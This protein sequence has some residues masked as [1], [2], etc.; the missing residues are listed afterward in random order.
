MDN[1]TRDGIQ[2]LQG[3]VLYA[4][5]Y[6]DAATDP[7]PLGG[8]AMKWNDESGSSVGIWYDDVIGLCTWLCRSSGRWHQDPSWADRQTCGTSQGKKQ[9]THTDQH[10]QWVGGSEPLL[11]IAPEFKTKSYSAVRTMFGTVTLSYTTDSER[12]SDACMI[13]PMDLRP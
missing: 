11:E 9:R 2:G 1:W 8:D 3:A 6:L 7:V 12:G 4:L 10:G 5:A 13:Q